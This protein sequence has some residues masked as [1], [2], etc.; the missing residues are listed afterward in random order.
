MRNCMN[1]YPMD[2][3]ISI[4]K[5][6]IVFVD[7][8]GEQKYIDPRK[9]SKIWYN[10]YHHNVFSLIGK[11]RNRYIGNRLWNIGKESVI[12]FFTDEKIQFVIDTPLDINS[13]EYMDTRKKWS[14]IIRQIQDSGWWLFDCN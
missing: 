11:R 9:C 10:Q 12:T 13:I 3:I 1:T 4:S 7:E 2:H 14:N 8:F 6:K 5:T